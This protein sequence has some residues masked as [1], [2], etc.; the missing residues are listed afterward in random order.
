M[1]QHSSVLRL[2]T[3]ALFAALAYIAF[4]FLKISIP[5]PAGYTAFH[6]G[7]TFCILAA[8]LLGGVPGG[9]AGAIGMGIGDI[10]DPFYITV[11]PKTII[12]KLGI[13]IITGLAAH[14][15]FHINQLEGKKLTK[16]VILS[17]SAGMA[18]NCIAEPLFGYF[19]TAYI[20]GAQQ[21]A[22]AALAAW[23]AVTTLT[24]A[25]L[26]VIISTLLYLA[27]RPRLK[28]NGTLQKLS[29]KE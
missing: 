28:N 1:N 21:K 14:K 24:N 12:L 29:P 15:F 9:I 10:L 16:A 20:L 11:A 7:N 4:T 3:T 2:C 22:A 8:L 27:I 26:A 13:G 17:T 5:T 18:F 6:L 25:I 23:N 19:Y